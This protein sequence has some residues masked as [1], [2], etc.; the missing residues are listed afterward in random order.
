MFGFEKGNT[1]G[2]IVFISYGVFWW[3]WALFIIFLKGETAPTLIGWYLYAW[4]M[5]SLV[6]FVATLTK[7][8]VLSGIFFFLTPTFFALGIGDGMEN[9]NIVH[10]DGCLGS[11][12]APSA[13][14][15]VATEATNKSLDKMVL[16]VG[17]RK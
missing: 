6:M 10:I 3:T 7:S 4:G 15:L 9:H 8:K 14:Y 17:E 13:L 12:T 16:P 11:A 2:L 1:S 5:S